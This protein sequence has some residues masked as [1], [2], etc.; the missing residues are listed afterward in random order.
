MG[1]NSYTSA[2]RAEFQGAKN[3]EFFLFRLTLTFKTTTLG[4]NSRTVY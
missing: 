1:L 4:I 2:F 3:A